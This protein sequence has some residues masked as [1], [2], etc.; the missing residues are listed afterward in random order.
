V[1]CGATNIYIGMIAPYVSEGTVLP[2]G[3]K[4]EKRKI[5]G[6]ESNGMLCSQKE[7]CLGD[8]HSGIIDLDK[9]FVLG[10]SLKKYVSDTVVEISTPANR[11]D[12]LGHSGI[13]RKLA[14][15]FGLNYT[16]EKTV[17]EETKNLPFYDLKIE[18][19]D[20][21][22]KYI[23]T[24]ITNVRNDIK[25]PF[26][27]RHRLSI[28]GV[29]SINPLVD[30]SNYVMLEVGHSVHIFDADK[31]EGN[32]IIVRRA[33]KDEKIL[34]LDGKE[35]ILSSENIVIADET[36]P[37]AIAG[38]IGGELSSVD[39]N[40][41]NIVI[42]SAIFNREMVRK[43]RKNLGVS[44]EAS[45]RFERG[46]GWGMCDRAAFK[47]IQLVLLYCGGKLTKFIDLKDAQYQ[48]NLSR[49]LK[50][51]LKFISNLLGIDLVEDDL[52]KVVK[53]LGGEIVFSEKTE[54][55]LCN[56]SPNKQVRLGVSS[57]CGRRGCKV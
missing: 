6:I 34:A 26:F 48:Q 44:T 20:L 28:C 41:K 29:R 16:P 15:K 22:P 8:D 52:F 24:N 19:P 3:I 7:L 40:T 21:C 47:T 11:F 9:D 32:K 33:K 57:R 46:S 49:K 1:V 35:Y 12:C 27:I 17:F 55:K 13:V 37:V 42:E 51:N 45:Y 56:Y 53:N 10:E 25:I 50:V 36:K 31:L 2:N 4:I 39:F 14:I 54:W 18:S 23:A 38:I 43:T 5:R 30:I